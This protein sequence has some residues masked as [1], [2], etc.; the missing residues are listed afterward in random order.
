MRGRCTRR[1]CRMAISAPRRNAVDPA[2][3]CQANGIR[4][5]VRGGWTF[6]K[7]NCG[8]LQ[9]TGSATARHM[10]V[11]TTTRVLCCV[12]VRF[13]SGPLGGLAH[14]HGALDTVQSRLSVLT[15]TLIKRRGA[16]ACGLESRILTGKTK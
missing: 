14:S 7:G 9:H 1:S 2:G 12:V 16:R 5:E 10:R 3:Q 6:F 11:A 4:D 13:R 15:G 8:F